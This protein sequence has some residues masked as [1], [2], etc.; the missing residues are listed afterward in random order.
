MSKPQ[1]H[2]CRKKTGEDQFCFGCKVHVCKKC[3]VNLCT[4][5]HVPIDH[6]R[7]LP[8]EYQGS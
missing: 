4:G 8:G 1:C 6:Y 3:D 2:L 7:Q 5:K